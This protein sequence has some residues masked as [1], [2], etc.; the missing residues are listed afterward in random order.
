[1]IRRLFFMAWGPA[2][3]A[4]ISYLFI[5]MVRNAMHTRLAEIPAPLSGSAEAIT[6]KTLVLAPGL[7]CGIALLLF[8]IFQHRFKG[9]SS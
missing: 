6:F 4:A 9:G 7:L 1:M 2:V 3:T 8:L 5:Q